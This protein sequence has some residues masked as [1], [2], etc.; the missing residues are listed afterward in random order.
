M[1]GSGPYVH[2]RREIAQF[3]SRLSGAAILCLSPAV[4]INCSKIEGKYND[5]LSM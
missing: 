4:N 3:C 2:A 5:N 1:A